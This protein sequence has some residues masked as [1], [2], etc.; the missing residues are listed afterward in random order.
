MVAH[1]FLTII[2]K[3]FG[4]NDIEKDIPIIKKNPPIFIGSNNNEF[5]YSNNNNNAG[6]DFLLFKKGKI[7]RANEN[8]KDR[9]AP[10]GKVPAPE[11]HKRLDASRS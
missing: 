10:P 5:P 3:T 2:T 6:R 9:R 1:A 8:L 7:S 11:N 4:K